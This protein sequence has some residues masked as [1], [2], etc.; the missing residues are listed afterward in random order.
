MFMRTLLSAVCLATTAAAQLTVI[1]SAVATTRPTLS[2]FYIGN[3]FYST[4]STTTAPA[5]RSQ[6]IVA[7]SDIAIPATL[8]NSLEVRR[9][10]G[11]GNA[12]VAFTAN[13][14]IMMSVSSSPWTASTGTFAT[15]H[16]PSPTTVLSGQISL[17]A[18]TN[19]PTWPAPWQT[20]FPFSAPFPYAGVPGGSLVIDVHQDQTGLVVGGTQWYV[21]Y[22]TPDIGG[23]YNNGGSAQSNCK[24][25]SGTYNSGLGYTTGGLAGN[26]GA[27]YVSYSGLLA[28]AP[29]IAALGFNGEGGNWNGI[30]LPIDLSPMGAPGCRWSV[31]ME[32]IVGLT[33]SATGSAQW[34]T[35]TIPNDP[36][37]RGASFYDHSLWID[38]LANS[39]GLV[40]GWSSRW[41][42]GTQIGAPGAFVVA[43][44][45]NHTAPSGTRTAGGMPSLRL[46]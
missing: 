22:T 46:Q 15:N 14:T 36:A 3:V 31:S 24:F 28:N 21:E 18:A 44:G 8:W 37:L 38:P 12:N 39:L 30:P 11:L 33:A 23:R 40:A 35:Q 6:M 25:S 19:G 27:W 41:G 7:T 42:I 1:P 10:I 20:P 2:P 34:P 45:N 32:V 4:T 16:G 5:S 13:A 26:G 17:P 29:G 9:P 43:T